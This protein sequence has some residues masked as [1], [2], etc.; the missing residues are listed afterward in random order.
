MHKVK[1][2]GVNKRILFLFYKSVI[3]SLVRYGITMLRKS[4]LVQT[5]LKI[6]SWE[7][8]RPIQ[9]MYVVAIVKKIVSFM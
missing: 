4:K 3:E 5:V 9:E 1:I 2:F 7:V 6:L 8:K